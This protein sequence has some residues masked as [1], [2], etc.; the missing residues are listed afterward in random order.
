MS[1]V[2]TLIVEVELQGPACA[3]FIR[4]LSGQDEAALLLDLQ[5]RDLMGAIW[6]ALVE[7]CNELK[8][9]AA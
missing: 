1:G 7:M 5:G 3:Y 4:C 8:G 2:P 6:D 9:E